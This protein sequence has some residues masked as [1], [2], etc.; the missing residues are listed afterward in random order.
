MLVRGND[1]VPVL[2]IFLNLV[3]PCSGSFRSKYDLGTVLGTVLEQG[4]VVL[5]R[6]AYIEN[7]EVSKTPF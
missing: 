1:L 6:P 3:V 5:R 2:P 7:L 4:R